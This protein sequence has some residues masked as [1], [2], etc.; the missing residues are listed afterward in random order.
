MLYGTNLF[1][2]KFVEHYF[3]ILFDVAQSH[4]KQFLQK[5]VTQSEMLMLTYIYN[6][7]LLQTFY[8]QNL[9]INVIC[10]ASGIKNLGK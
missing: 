1:R 6:V 9:N 4:R 7:E 2:K 10:I 3:L 8:L 5:F